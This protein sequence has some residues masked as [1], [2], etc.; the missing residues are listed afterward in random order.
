MACTVPW[1]ADTSCDQGWADY[2]APTQE[3]ALSLA[4]ST[5]RLLTAGRVGSCQVEDRPCT[6][7]SCDTCATGWMHPQ[8]VDG[9]WVN[10]MCGS[11]GCS[12]K[13]HEIL[14]PSAAVV[15]EVWVD[16]VLLLDYEW[17]LDRS[18]RLVRTDGRPWPVCSDST[19]EF[20]E[21]GSFSVMYVP[22]IEPDA[23]GLMAAGVLASE[24]AKACS[25]AKCR[26]PGT[27]TSVVRQGVSVSMTEGVFA[28]GITGVREVD[29]W[30]ATVNPHRLVTPPTVWSPDAPQHRYPAAAL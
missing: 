13:V 25:G 20:D 28:G 22:G 23:A 10:R 2:D 14:L 4:W 7:D 21:P 27:V 3:R 24:Y 29:V 8:I 17:R 30:V 15:R 9:T 18:N 1:V 5:L 11:S 12:C 19:A 26:L 16:G 6:Q